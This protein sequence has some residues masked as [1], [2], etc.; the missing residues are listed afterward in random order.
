MR[1][2]IL[3]ILCSFFVSVFTLPIDSGWKSSG[4]SEPL[5]SNTQKQSEIAVSRTGFNK[6]TSA[7]AFLKA[8]GGMPMRD[9]RF[10]KG[11]ESP[12]LGYSGPLSPWWPWSQF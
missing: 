11:Q 2:S 5:S 4:G 6:K 8:T 7:K 10:F 1:S 3:L 12:A 9:G